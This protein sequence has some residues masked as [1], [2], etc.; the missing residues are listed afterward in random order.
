MTIY[1]INSSCLFIQIR[2]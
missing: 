1:L 2:L